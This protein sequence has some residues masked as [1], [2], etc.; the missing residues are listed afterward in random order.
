MDERTITNCH[1]HLFTHDNIPDDYFP[2][3]LVQAL[4]IAPLRWLLT[5]IMKAIVPWTDNDKIHRYAAFVRAAYRETQ[6]ANL[7]HLMG[8]YPTGT[9]FVVLPM[10]MALMGAGEVKE[11]I[12]DQHFELA[13][14][15]MDDTYKHILIPFAHIDPRRSNA[16]RRLKVMVEKAHFR[17]VKIYPTLGYGPDHK[18]LMRVIYPYMVAKNIPLLAHCS[19]GV[20]NSRDMPVDKA[21]ALADPDNYKPVMRAFPDLRICLAHFGGPAE[22][23][24][25]INGPRDPD[26]PTWLTKI[27]D[28][29]TSGDYPNLYTDVSYTVFRFSENVPLLKLLLLEPELLKK[30]LFGSDYY[31]V[32]REKYSEKRISIDLRCALGEAMFWK[33]ASQNPKTYLGI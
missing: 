25:H 27:R 22:W 16:G 15:C 18:V 20:V 6:K 26:D 8:Y 11:D 24:R 33:I 19:K 30:T 21:H 23:D 12:D 32:E 3:Y 17:G 4:R 7:E 31:M 2:F 14:L 1:T 13:R 5:A 9:R 29:I 10:D 28:L